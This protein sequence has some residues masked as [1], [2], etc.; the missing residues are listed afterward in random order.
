[1]KEKD[2]DVYLALYLPKELLDKIDECVSEKLSN[3]SQ[4]VREI[5]ANHFK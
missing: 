2:K 1:M 4:V 3:R 5:I